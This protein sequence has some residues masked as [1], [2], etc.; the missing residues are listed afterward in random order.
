MK[1][2]T[3]T[4][5]ITAL[6]LVANSAY[7]GCDPECAD[8]VSCR[9]NA[10]SGKYHCDVSKGVVGKKISPTEGAGREPGVGSMLP[11]APR[12]ISR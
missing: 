4:L 7:A 8:G 11:K 2:Q 5:L 10:T 3:H 12:K 6:F 9:Y 1:I